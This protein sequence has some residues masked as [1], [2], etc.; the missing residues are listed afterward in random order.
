MPKD[1]TGGHQTMGRRTHRMQ[2]DEI[3][4]PN[5]LPWNAYAT[6]PPTCESRPAERQLSVCV[7]AAASS[8]ID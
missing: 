4:E 1:M 7:E 3:S 6:A 8:K 5:Q 2:P